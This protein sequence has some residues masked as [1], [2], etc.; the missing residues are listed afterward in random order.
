MRKM[1]QS[2]GNIETRYKGPL[3]WKGKVDEKEAERQRREGIQDVSHYLAVTSQDHWAMNHAREMKK[4]WPEPERG[5]LEK[6]L[7]RTPIVKTTVGGGLLTWR[8][9]ASTA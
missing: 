8:S 9:G 4:E 6:V 2:E 7:L 1:A 3:P 5:D